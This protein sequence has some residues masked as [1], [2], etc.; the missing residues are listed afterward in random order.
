MTNPAARGDSRLSEVS[1]IRSVLRNRQRG[2]TSCAGFFIQRDDTNQWV[3]TEAFEQG[4]R[5]WE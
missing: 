1:G 3:E 2:L 5:L 4:G